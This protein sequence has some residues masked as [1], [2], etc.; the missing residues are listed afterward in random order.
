MLFPKIN[1]NYVDK[2]Q[3]VIYVKIKILKWLFLKKDT[4]FYER[5][6]TLEDEFYQEADLHVKESPERRIS[7]HIFGI[8]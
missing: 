2:M 4:R 5:Q 7:A 8:I 6:H 3:G 1:N